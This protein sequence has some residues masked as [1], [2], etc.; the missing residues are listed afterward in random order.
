MQG[1]GLQKTCETSISALLYR[2]PKGVSLCYGIAVVAPQ[3]DGFKGSMFSNEIFK[4]KMRQ[5]FLS[6]F[7][8]RPFEVIIPYFSVA[9]KQASKFS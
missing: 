5:H 8:R 3:C 6:A 1:A 7:H 4:F 9:I 2:K